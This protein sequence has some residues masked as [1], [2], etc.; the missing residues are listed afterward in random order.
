MTVL[1]LI[2]SGMGHSEIVTDEQT[3]ITNIIIRQHLFTTHS[4]NLSD[5][6]LYIISFVSCC[7]YVRAAQRISLM[8]LYRQK[9]PTIV[10]QWQMIVME[11]MAWRF[12][13]IA[14]S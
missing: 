9:T 1:Y 3:D 5:S 7:M 12:Q 10:A 11:R 8:P 6:F 2:E 4:L 14:S 13:L